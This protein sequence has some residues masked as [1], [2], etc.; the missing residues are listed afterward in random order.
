MLLLYI[1]TILSTV[2]LSYIV[3]PFETK[4]LLELRKSSG[5]LGKD[6]MVF[7]MLHILI[8]FVVSDYHLRTEMPSAVP[9][10]LL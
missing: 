10:I 8:D 3:S 7:A 5:N 1:C 9:D 6:C 2:Q 4:I